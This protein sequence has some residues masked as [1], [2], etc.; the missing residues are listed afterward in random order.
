M[1][2]NTHLEQ[3]ISS[4]NDKVEELSYKLRL[5][6]ISTVP[7]PEHEFYYWLACYTTSE[8]MKF[9]LD[10]ALRLLSDK[11][12]NKSLDIFEEKVKR[13]FP[14]LTSIFSINVCTPEEVT[15]LLQSTFD[16]SKLAVLHL[17]ECLYSNEKFKTLS[18]FML[19]ANSEE[20][21]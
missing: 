9:K 1:D 21:E 17:F 13:D 18:K 4:L 7:R 3:Q 2:K 6:S 15:T 10:V 20:P 16:L 19:D 8:A 11:L 5:L 14:D 12:Q